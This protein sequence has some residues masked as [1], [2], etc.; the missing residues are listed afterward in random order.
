MIYCGLRISK[1]TFLVLRILFL[2]S[3][4]LPIFFGIL[5]VALYFQTYYC[6]N[7][8]HPL[9]LFRGFKNI[10][11]CKQKH[12]YLQ[13]EIRL[14]ASR[15]HSICSQKNAQGKER[16]K[17]NKFNNGQLLAILHK[18]IGNNIDVVHKAKSAS[19]V[20]LTAGRIPRKDLARDI[21]EMF[22]FVQHDKRGF[23][24]LLY[25]SQNISEGK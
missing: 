24:Q 12:F 1:C 16:L 4:F 17:T 5:C 14:T 18:N 6:R 3:R 2:F 23:G 7:Q 13:V 25:Y 20:I 11:N 22:H 15:K 10:S 8:D 21:C 19:V 9:P